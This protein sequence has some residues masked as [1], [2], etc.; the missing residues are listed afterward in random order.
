M[1]IYQ[2][3][4]ML[5]VIITALVA[6]CAGSENHGIRITGDL[7]GLPDGEIFLVNEKNKKL[8][9]TSS[10]NGKFSFNIKPG[11]YEEPGLF[12]FEHVDSAQNRRLFQFQ[13][14]KKLNGGGLMLQC[15]MLAPG[16][17]VKVKGKLKEFEAKNI[18][19]PGNIKLVYP[20]ETITG[21]LQNDVMYREDFFTGEGMT[22]AVFR[23]LH[24]KVKRYPYSHYF[25]HELDKNLTQFSNA[26]AG[27]LVAS[28][29]SIRQQSPT[30]K[31]I[32]SRLTDRESKMLSRSTLMVNSSDVSKP[33]IDP[34]KRVNIVV[35]WASWCGPCRKEIPSLKTLYKKL[36]H[37]PDVRIVSVSLDRNRADWLKAAEE[38]NM[39]WEQL[40]LPSGGNIRS[41]DI[42]PFDGTIPTTLITDSYGK[43]LQKYTGF[44]DDLVQKYETFT[45][46]YLSR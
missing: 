41:V 32:I 23:Q 1:K 25:L 33:V 7:G 39:P 8:D 13:T 11:T 5:S 20:D 21:L 29:D 30:G 12:S 35:L 2:A 17:V 18:R 31:R 43:V 37:Q 15:F 24:E 38:E 22:D 45:A 27:A 4:F 6:G 36:E 34:G 19:L 44:E 26:Q 10:L 16:D 42:F 9:S 28:F 46:G 14:Q 40:W 3:S